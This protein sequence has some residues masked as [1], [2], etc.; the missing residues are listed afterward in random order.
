MLGEAQEEKE[1]EDGERQYC[2][3]HRRPTSHSIQDCQDFLDLVQ[4][5]MDEGRIEFFKEMKG[6]AMNVLQGETPKSVIIHYRGG[7]Q[8]A[9]TKAPICSIPRVMIKVLTPFQYTSDKA[10]PWNYTSK[11]VSPEPQAV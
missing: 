8:Q 1:N 6:Q 5:L 2:Q 9:P 7:G 11:V 3:Y 10:I 4:G